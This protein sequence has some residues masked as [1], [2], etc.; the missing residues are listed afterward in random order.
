MQGIPFYRFIFVVCFFFFFFGHTVQ[1]ALSD[2]FSDQG[3]NLCT[4]QLKHKVLTTGSPWN[5]LDLWV[6]VRF[7]GLEIQGQRSQLAKF[8]E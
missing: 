5:S 7:S 3:S 1:L 8:V 4:Q 6:S 2:K